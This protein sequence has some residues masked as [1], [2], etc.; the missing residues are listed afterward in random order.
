M[1]TDAT[2]AIEEELWDAGHRWVVGCDEVG[3]GS[4]AGPLLIAACAVSRAHVTDAPPVADSKALRPSNRP[5]LADAVR[6]WAPVG[7]GEATVAE[8]DTLGM[9]AALRLAANRALEALHADGVPV[10]AVIQDGS[11][12]WIPD[13]IAAAAEVRVLPKADARCVSVAAA[14]VVAKVHRDAQMAELGAAWPSW[15]AIGRSAGYG[16]PAH[17]EQIR[18]LG[19]TPLHR[20]SWAFAEKLCGPDPVVVEVDPALDAAT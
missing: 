9:A 18:S 3:R 10:T 8:I 19:L 7:L 4:W 2:F 15:P 17:A 5:A 11:A 6:S 12:S 16:T 1:G 14:S 20:R 13:D